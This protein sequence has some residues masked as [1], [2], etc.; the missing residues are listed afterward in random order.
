M[1]VDH[2]WWNLIHPS[3][4]TREMRIW[5]IQIGI[6]LVLHHKDHPTL[7]HRQERC[8]H[9]TNGRPWR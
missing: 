7:H 5:C 1:S 9:P 8:T 3:R 6:V 4:A 2:L